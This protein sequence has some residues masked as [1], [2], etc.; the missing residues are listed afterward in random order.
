MTFS[1][2]IEP[3]PDLACG[4]F[5]TCFPQPLGRM[6]SAPRLA[7]LLALDAAAPLSRDE[8][9]R[10]AIRDLLRR[11]GYKPTGR[12]KPAS[13]YL[14]RAAGEGALA[15]I[16]LAVDACN[17]VS[18]H[19]GLPI[20]VIDLD[21]TAP[22]L[23]IAVAAAGEAYVFNVSGQTIAVEGLPCVRDARGP[24]ANA[25]KDAQR[26]KTGPETRRTLSVVWACDGLAPKLAAATAWYRALLHEAGAATEEAAIDASN[27]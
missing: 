8:E 9:T 10:A 23:S 18:L 20:S 11:R 26:T 19:S 6:P 14:V 24:C 17:A 7:A 1:L 15:P 25:V 5:A 12:G 21:L 4:V 13:E 3:Y 2:R 16:N 27:A 22:P